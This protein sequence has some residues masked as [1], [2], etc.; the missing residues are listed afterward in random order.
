MDGS[1][2]ERRGAADGAERAAWA[3]KTGGGAERGARR[4][5]GGRSRQRTAPGQGSR[6]T[7]GAGAAPV[8]SLRLC[9]REAALC[10][11]LLA[12]SRILCSSCGHDLMHP[13]DAPLACR[14]AER[15]APRAGRRTARRQSSRRQR[16]GAR[17]R[18]SPNHARC[19]AARVWLMAASLRC[20]QVLLP[21]L[22]RQ[23]A[24]V[25]RSSAA[26]ST[27]RS[28]TSRT[29]LARARVSAAQRPLRQAEHSCR[30]LL[31]LPRTHPCRRASDA[32]STRHRHW[33]LVPHGVPR[34]APEAAP[35]P[36]SAECKARGTMLAEPSGSGRRE[37][38]LAAA[39]AILVVQ[40]PPSVLHVLV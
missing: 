33:R 26:F 37:R 5:G 21:C 36:A 27:H 34:A 24:R 25:P 30:R 18:H 23:P 11:A 6:S 4:S 29:R 7:A 12:L 40:R 32:D 28:R 3:L 31:L 39:A 17:R 19:G 22:P 1:E 10:L 14:A 2:G 8:P 13:R 15:G 9:C 35:A 38:P 16:P 20:A